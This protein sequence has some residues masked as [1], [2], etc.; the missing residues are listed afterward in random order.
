MSYYQKL[1]ITYP[2]AHCTYKNFC[3]SPIWFHW[4]TQ[5]VNN[6]YHLSLCLCGFKPIL[7]SCIISRRLWRLACRPGSPFYPQ[8]IVTDSIKYPIMSLYCWQIDNM[9]NVL[10]LWS[11][12]KMANW[13][14]N[15]VD[16]VMS[17]LSIG[18]S[19]L[20][21]MRCQSL[22]NVDLG[23]QGFNFT[24]NCP[25]DILTSYLSSWND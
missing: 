2:I 4:S 20:L 19:C 8:W 11:G 5:E 22:R 7:W 16:Y 10:M 25:R 12:W 21:L 3:L 24:S 14:N 17:F 1:L 13:Y 23:Y 15:E 9:L 6:A 18:W